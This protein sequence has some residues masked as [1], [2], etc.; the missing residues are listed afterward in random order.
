M[1]IENHIE[2]AKIFQIGSN[3]V[4]NIK[5]INFD[6]IKNYEETDF[7]ITNVKINNVENEFCIMKCSCL[8]IL[9]YLLIRMT[10]KYASIHTALVSENNSCKR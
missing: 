8:Q 6:I 5:I 4:K 3:K 1:N 7:L 10:D 2:F 9:S